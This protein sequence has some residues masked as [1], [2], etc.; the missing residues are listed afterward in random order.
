MEKVI[1]KGID[2]DDVIAVPQVSEVNHL[3][4]VNLLSNLKGKRKG[5]K[6]LPIFSSPM[7]GISGVEL[8]EECDNC[9]ILGIL[10]RFY[11]FDTRI[12]NID[13]LYAHNVDFGVAVGI[14]NEEQELLIAEKAYDL[15]ATLIC[16]DVA[17][18]YI[19]DLCNFI[20]K[21]KQR[22][23]IPIMT[24]NVVTRSGVQQLKNA[25]ADYVRVGIGSGNLC[26]TRDYV[27]IGMPQ[28]TALQQCS[29]EYVVPLSRPKIVSDGGIL[30][31]ARALKSFIFGADFIMLGSIFGSA[32]EAEN[33]DNKIYGMASRRNQ[34]DSYG[35]VRSVEGREQTVDSKVSLSVIVEEFTNGLKSGCAYLGCRD[36]RELKDVVELVY[37]GKGTLK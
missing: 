31:P 15:G 35:F 14:R 36:Y 37:T 2:Y 18:G 10:H 5:K 4:D 29:E 33:T 17:N 1:Y 16:V 19:S 30:T 21:L 20:E 27:G 6:L 28:L 12:R 26:L 13:L 9:D 25:G 23:V 24:G 32:L 34:I 3:D 22:V 7:K 11:D 8:V